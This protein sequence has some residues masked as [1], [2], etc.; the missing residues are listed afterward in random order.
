MVKNEVAVMGR[1]NVIK[2]I[3]EDIVYDGPNY[4]ITV[5]GFN[6]DESVDSSYGSFGKISNLKASKK[7]LDLHYF[8][9]ELASGMFEDCVM[10]SF[11]MIVDK[12][13]SAINKKYIRGELR[14]IDEKGKYFGD[15]IVFDLPIVWDWESQPDSN[16]CILSS[17]KTIDGLKGTYFDKIYK[18]LKDS[19]QGDKLKNRMELKLI[20]TNAKYIKPFVNTDGLRIRIKRNGG[21]A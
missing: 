13:W 9:L 10:I 8:C 2:F 3:I 4:G 19:Y 6:F 12:H 1:G 14:A 11:G 21:K 5:Y 20:I 18:V 17:V 7:L 15:S 16:R